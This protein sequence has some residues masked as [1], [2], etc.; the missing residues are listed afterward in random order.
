MTYIHCLCIIISTQMLL[1]GTTRLYTL[2]QRE[3]FSSHS[4]LSSIDLSL[5]ELHD[6]SPSLMTLKITQLVQCTGPMHVI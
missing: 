2:H 3:M 4:V 6:L 5:E 1:L